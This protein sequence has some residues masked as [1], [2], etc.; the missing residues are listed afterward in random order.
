MY[1]LS[2]DSQVTY[3]IEGF[4]EKNKD[5]LPEPVVDALRFTSLQLLG[6]LFKASGGG[7]G[8]DRA[9]HLRKSFLRKRYV[10]T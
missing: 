9:D 5:S 1:Y 3:E 6:V 4:L 2:C 10:Y 8:R 7:G